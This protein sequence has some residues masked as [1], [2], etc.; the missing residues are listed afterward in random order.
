MIVDDSHV[1][2][3]STIISIK[4]MLLDCSGDLEQIQRLINSKVDPNITDYDHRTPLHTV[5]FF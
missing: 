4:L 2:L 5:G 3:Y 1:Q